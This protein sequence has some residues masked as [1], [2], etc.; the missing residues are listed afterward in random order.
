MIAEITKRRNLNPERRERSYPRVVKR[1]RHNSYRVKKPTDIGVRHDAEPTIR[2]YP[3]TPRGQ[4]A[5]AVPAAAPTP[6]PAA[7]QRPAP[8]PR[9]ARDRPRQPR[10]HRKT[11]RQKTYATA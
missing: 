7:R 9:T 1:A 6:V 8:P 3:V 10:E 4:E 11:A 2:F 5:T